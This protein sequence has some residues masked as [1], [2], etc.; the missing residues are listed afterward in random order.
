MGNS[1]HCWVING[2]MKCQLLIS[3]QNSCWFTVIC[4]KET[5]NHLVGISL[6]LFSLS[7][8][9]SWILIKL[10]SWFASTKV[11]CK[12]QN[13]STVVILAR[14]KHAC[15]SLHSVRGNFLQNVCWAVKQCLR[16]NLGTYDRR[17]HFTWTHKTLQIWWNQQN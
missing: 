2:V 6:S 14:G 7:L 5:G 12:V 16:E 1:V 11:C 9:Q 3:F 17:S 10:I 13:R 8:R 4:T 15:I